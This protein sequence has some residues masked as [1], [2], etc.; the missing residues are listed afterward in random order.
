MR[1]FIGLLVT[2]MISLG[3]ATPSSATVAA[4]VQGTVRGPG[5]T[6][7]SGAKVEALTP[8][9]TTV[10]ATTTTDTLGLYSLAV[11]EGTYDLRFTGPIGSSLGQAVLPASFVSGTTVRDVTLLPALV[12]LSGTVRNSAGAPLNYSYVTFSGG[13]SFR[14]SVTDATGHYSITVAPGTYGSSIGGGIA[15]TIPMYFGLSGAA[16]SVTA[17]AT[18]DL[19]V[20]TVPVTIHIV[21]ANG[22]PVNGN[23]SATASGTSVVPGVHPSMV[24]TTGF[25][26]TGTSGLD[27]IFYGFAGTARVSVSAA[28]NPGTSQII[29][30]NPTGPNDFTFTLPSVVN[31]SGTVTTATGS[32]IHMASV[33]LNDG[34]TNN[35]VSTDSNGHYSFNVIPGVYTMS[36]GGGV[37][38]NIPPYYGLTS[39]QF[40]I[41]ANTVFDLI[42]PTVAV[43][44][45]IFDSNGNPTSGV[46]YASF[47]ASAAVPGVSPA[48]SFSTVHWQAGTFGLDPT[49]YGFPGTANVIVTAPG[50][51]GVTQSVVIDPAGPNNLSVTLPAVVT[52]S[53]TVVN[54]AGQ[55]LNQSSISATPASGAWVGGRTDANGHYSFSVIPGLY[56]I[57]IGGGAA[58]TIPMYFGLTSN[59]TSITTDTVLDLVVPTVPVTV[60]VLNEFGTSVAAS[61]GANSQGIS[62]VPG[63]HPA[64]TFMTNFWNAGGYGVDPTFYALASDSMLSI[65][66]PGRPT[67]TQPITI[68]STG[69]NEYTFLISGAVVPGGPT[70]SNDGDNVANVVEALAPHAG[71]GNLD[72]TQDW[73]QA[74]V[75]SLPVFG[76]TSGNDYVTVAAPSGTTLQNVY[77]IDST[78][79][80]K[81]PTA[82]PVGVTLPEGLTNFVLAGVP[83]GGSTTVSIYT[84]ST[85][86]INGYAKYNKTTDTWTLLPQSLV[87]VL[88]DH[89]DI[90]LTDGGVG[91]DDQTA[92]GTIV[93]PG[94]IARITDTTSPSITVAGITDGATY[95]LGTVL[96]PNC[97]ASDI[98][99]GLAGPCT[100]T[101]TGGNAL[102]VGEFTYTATAADLAGNRATTTIRYSVRYRFD[103][104]SDPVVK[105]IYT[106]GDDIPIRFQLK[107]ADGTVVTTSAMPVWVTPIRVSAAGTDL[108]TGSPA[109]TAPSFVVNGKAWMGKWQSKGVAPGIY[110]LN[111]RL[112]DGSTRSI[113][114]TLKR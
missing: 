6:G 108:G 50:N 68:T 51:P 61:A 40:S 86:G 83:V 74:N 36:I 4:Q 72:G 5:G 98:G 7:L 27:P 12:T 110:R 25:W 1:R 107:R 2:A 96:S 66:V 35:G 70:T 41:V 21:D 3:F 84:G 11:D 60:H 23:V 63:V 80:S 49:F 54:S 19:T 97:A 28:G 73:R 8:A 42:I 48:L 64:L 34:T 102:G 106:A 88:S 92:N 14:T 87:V 112:D 65:F 55:P 22:N 17:D 37:G 9:T 104:F 67:I 58:P 53:G 77:T 95:L 91:D 78:D 33:S 39:G 94:G 56:T 114:I 89:V 26:N 75:T 16:M 90:R 47:S 85:A 38:P 32:P 59:Q 109:G 82:P 101:I 15:A 57:S 10:V 29:T 46:V 79:R 105:E 76:A 13:G 52:L 69:P 103:G 81:V 62:T 100:A 71:D 44:V 113:T 99:S 111:I 31:V 18:I 30:I 24:F 93:D 20:P 45:H 43:T